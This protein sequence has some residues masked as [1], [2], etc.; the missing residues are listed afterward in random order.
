MDSLSLSYFLNT[1]R[2]AGMA[3]FA[4]QYIP[5][6]STGMTTTNV[7][8]SDPPITNAMIIAKRNISGARIAV[9]TSIIYA[10]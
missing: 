7:T 9:R 5:R 8:A 4:I 1:A 3:F 2:N 6:P 10:N